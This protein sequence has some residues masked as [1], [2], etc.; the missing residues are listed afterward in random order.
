MSRELKFRIYVPQDKGFVYFGLQDCPQGI[1]GAVSEPMQF[2]GL[3]DKNGKEIYEGDFVNSYGKSIGEIL[4]DNPI[5]SCGKVTWL[6]ESWCL[7]QFGV[8]GNEISNYVSCDCCDT[9]LEIIGNIHEN[10][11]LLK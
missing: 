10:P 3:K 11:E 6:R 5:Y 1:Y 2:T 7:C 8:G 9:T 4:S